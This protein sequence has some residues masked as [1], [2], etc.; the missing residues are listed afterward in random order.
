MVTNG[1]A[2]ESGF[3]AVNKS[4]IAAH[5]HHVVR[6]FNGYVQHCSSPRGKAISDFSAGLVHDSWHD[7]RLFHA[8]NQL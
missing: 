4:A 7:S 5:R 8:E 6:S 1:R 2:K 3:R